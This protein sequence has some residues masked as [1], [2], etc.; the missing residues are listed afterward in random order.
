MT[1]TL[2]SSEALGPDPLAIFRAWYAEAV[3]K[4][5]PAPDALALATATADGK[6]SVRM[7]LYKG[8]E[9]ERL[10]LVTNYESRKARELAENPWAALAF[11]WPGLDRQVRLE[12]RV[13]RAPAALSD[14]YFAGRDRESQ[15]GAWASLQSHPVASR[16]ELEGAL[17]RERSRWEGRPVE[18]P[19]HWGMLLLEPLRVEFW[20]SGPHRLHDRFAYEATATGWTITRLAP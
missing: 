7:V 11:Y 12:G 6:P 10:C 13:E 14:R 20:L 9:A 18:R 16:A 4:K 1:A 15:L 3:E 17:A 2:P 5:L 19:P 8:F